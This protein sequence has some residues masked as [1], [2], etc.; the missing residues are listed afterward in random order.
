MFEVFGRP[1]WL[2]NLAG[3][4]QRVRSTVSV[5]PLLTLT[6]ARSLTLL[7]SVLPFKKELFSIESESVSHSVTSNSLQPHAL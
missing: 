6:L 3:F 1:G 5:L 7:F 2:R 4:A